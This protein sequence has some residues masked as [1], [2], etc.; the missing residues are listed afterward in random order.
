MQAVY[1]KIFPGNNL[2]KSCWKSIRNPGGSVSTDFHSPGEHGT[3]YSSTGW[4]GT[5]MG[6]RYYY[7]SE[8]DAKY[9]AFMNFLIQASQRHLVKPDLSGTADGKSFFVK[10]RL[11]K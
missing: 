10:K 3:V 6:E 11:P 5:L 7:P 9:A 1:V 8:K 4:N 2:K